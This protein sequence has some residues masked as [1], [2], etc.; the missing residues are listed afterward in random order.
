MSIKKANVAGSEFPAC[1]VCEKPIASG[2]ANTKSYCKLCG[3]D[4]EN[5]SEFCCDECEG[6]FNRYAHKEAN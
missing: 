1:T 5:G 2:A 6:T 3:M 4:T